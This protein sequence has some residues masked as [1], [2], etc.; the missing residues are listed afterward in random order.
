M[1]KEVRLFETDEHPRLSSLEKLSQLK[2]AF[3]KEGT[4]TAGNSSGINDGAAAM[5]LASEGAVKK[6][7][8]NPI[9]KVIGMA[10]AGVEP[11]LM[12]IGTC[13]CQ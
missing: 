12:G 9:G 1:G 5:L 7:G 10:V 8:L 3:S 13:P 6:F 2:P 4:V 11:A